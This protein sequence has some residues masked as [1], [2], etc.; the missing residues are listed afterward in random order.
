MHIWIIQYIQEHDISITEVSGTSIGAIIAG[1]YATG[2]SAEEM[3]EAFSGINYRMFF[4]GNIDLGVFGGKNIKTRLTWIFGKKKIEDC[5]IPCSII[6]WNLHTGE[7]KI[8]RKGSLVDAVR[9]SMSLPWIIS[10][11]EIDG[12]M[13][14]DGGIVNNLPVDV[15]K[16]KN[17]I[18]SSCAD[19][20]YDT[21]EEKKEFLG[22]ALPDFT[23]NKVWRIL[24]NSIQIMLKTI[25]DLTI[26]HS[27]KELILIRPDLKEYSVF[28]MEKLDEIIKL[29]YDD[30]KK[31]LDV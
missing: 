2:M 11:Y 14:I 7:E 25:E 3:Q 18:A 5:D 21:L 31:V 8:F 13:Y 15:L 26:E 17:I 30:A 6:A 28:D 27:T 16:S 29:G 23:I 10:P 12:N 20:I 1:M 4:D 9:A 22:I 24:N 19:T